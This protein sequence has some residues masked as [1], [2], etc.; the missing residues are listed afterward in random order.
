MISPPSIEELSAVTGQ[1][2]EQLTRDA[3]A[4]KQNP[5]QCDVCQ[6]KEA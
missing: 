4:F 2:V 1:S 3:H 6:H 5:C